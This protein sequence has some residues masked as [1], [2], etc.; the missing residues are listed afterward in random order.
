MLALLF[1]M[2]WTG[3]VAQAGSTLPPLF[4]AETIAVSTGSQSSV[5][6]LAPDGP[7]APAVNLALV[8]LV[9]TAFTTGLNAEALRA[10]VD[11]GDPRAAWVLA[12][13]LR[14]HQRGVERAELVTAFTSLTGVEP[15]TSRNP[16]FVWTFNQ[17]IAWDLPVW[18]GY[19]ELKRRIY[20][21]F[22]ERWD[23]FFEEDH[24]VDW[25]MVTWGGVFADS[26]P[27]GDN[28]PCNCIPA[29]DNVATTDAGGGEWYA[30]ERVV[31]GVVVSGEALALPRHQMEVHE[32]VNLTLGGRSLG[33]PY[34]TLCGS[35][36]AYFTDGIRGID[37]LVLRTSGLLSRSNKVMYDLI[38]NSV[39]DTFTGEA[40]TG[41]LA[42]AGVV[43]EQVS[44]VV[45]TWGEWKAAH[46][47]TRIVAE[48]GGIGRTYPDDPLRGRDDQGPIFPVGEVDPRLPVQQKVI[49][50]VPL[51]GPPVAF[52]VAA[53][54]DVLIEEGEIEFDEL[55]VRLTDGFRVF[56]SDGVELPTHEAFW[57]AWSQFHPT[58][59]L[60]TP[61]QAR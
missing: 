31:F 45:A 47:A 34:C 15:P 55:I 32:M 1:V 16:D 33:I 37:R 22:D 57:F 36:Q 13:L 17:L 2:A 35:A 4:R 49:G 40:V 53:V 10:V 46:P 38:T 60:W 39:F 6:P 27:F 20:T 54:R 42:D 41:E 28:G 14:F 58:T 25:R 61:V 50:V 18:E 5:S 9:E 19:A 23:P 51:T 44:V 21:S 7:L 43:L 30:D 3:G 29:L 8:D 48:D 12:D 52:P 56:G 59:L 24:G 11:G 26:R